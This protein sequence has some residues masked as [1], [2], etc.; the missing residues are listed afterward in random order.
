MISYN[1][2]FK[3]GKKHGKG[4][5]EYPVAEKKNKKKVIGEAIE[6]KTKEEYYEGMFEDGEFN[7]KG[8]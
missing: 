2:Q 5:L 7:G 6:E 3:Q 1:G 4:K 8:V